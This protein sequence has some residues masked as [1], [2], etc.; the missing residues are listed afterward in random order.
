VLH[1]GQEAGGDQDGHDQRERALHTD[2]QERVSTGARDKSRTVRDEDQG[3]TNRCP[4]FG[5]G[6]PRD[7]LH[8]SAREMT[9][10]GRDRTLRTGPPEHADEGAM[11]MNLHDMRP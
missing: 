2:L 4:S 7:P 9:R 5:T 11:T 3:A 10:T 6:T 8:E 1:R